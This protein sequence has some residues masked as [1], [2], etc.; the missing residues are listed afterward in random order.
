MI[1]FE[2]VILRVAMYFLSI[3]N[4]SQLLDLVAYSG[5]KFVGA[6]VTLAVAEVLTGGRGT[7]GAIGWSIFIYTYLANAFFLVSVVSK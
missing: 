7:G 4:E 6:I 1:L 3:S 2:I 5:Y